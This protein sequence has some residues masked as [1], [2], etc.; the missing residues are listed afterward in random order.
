ML[1]VQIFDRFVERSPAVVMVR[2]SLE[3]SLRPERLDQIFEDFAQRQYTR[4][5]LFSELVALMTAV[6]TRHF[7]KSCLCRGVD[8]G[9]FWSEGVQSWA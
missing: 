8:G 9:Q 1:P 4:Q 5:L 6:T 2:A 3:R 7:L